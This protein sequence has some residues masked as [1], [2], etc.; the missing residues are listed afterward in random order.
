[1][2][3][4]LTLVNGALRFDGIFVRSIRHIPSEFFDGVSNAIASRRHPQK[5]NRPKLGRLTTLARNN[6]RMKMFFTNTS[7]QA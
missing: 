1:M 7:R 2:R 3:S 6:R 5:P 4:R